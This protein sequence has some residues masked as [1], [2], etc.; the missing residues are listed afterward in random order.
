METFR[1][2]IVQ[3]LPKGVYTTQ[4]GEINFHHTNKFYGTDEPMPPIVE[5]G[6][7][8]PN[9]YGKYLYE[10]D[11]PAY[12]KKKLIPND[13]SSFL[14]ID[15]E[16]LFPDG[17]SFDESFKAADCP[18]TCI[19]IA[20]VYS[21]D[22]HQL[23]LEDFESEDRMIE[24]YCSLVSGSVVIAYNANFDF[25]YIMRRYQVLT[26]IRLNWIDPHLDYISLYK[27]YKKF[28]KPSFKLNDIL[29][30]HLG[31]GKLQYEGSL[32]QLYHTDREK[33]FEYNREDV[34]RL[35]TLERKLKLLDICQHIIKITGCLWQDIIYNSKI[36]DS[37]FY[38]ELSKRGMTFI[39]NYNKHNDDNEEDS[40]EGAVV[41]TP[42]GG[43]YRNSVACYD[44]DSLYPSIILNFNISPETR[45]TISNGSHIRTP[46]NSYYK[47][48]TGLLP[49][50]I[51]YL[52]DARKKAKAEG[53]DEEQ[54]AYKILANSIYGVMGFKKFRLYNEK[55]AEDITL[56]GRF[57][58]MYVAHN[59]D[60]Q[61]SIT[62][63]DE[64]IIWGYAKRREESLATTNILFGHTDSIYVNYPE[65]LA[66]LINDDLLVYFSETY[67]TVPTDYK[68]RVKNE[69]GT[70]KCAIFLNRIKATYFLM[71]QDN[72]F[73]FV[74][75][76]AARS[77][78][79]K[80]AK[81]ILK[82]C[83]EKLMT[84][85]YDLEDIDVRIHDEWMDIDRSNIE[86]WKP[87]KI[88]WSKEYKAIPEC[89]KGLS[90][91]QTIDP[92][93][94]ELEDRGILVHVLG[95]PK[96][97]RAKKPT[98]HV[99]SIP[100]SKISNLDSLLSKLGDYGLKLN[101]NKIYDNLFKPIND[102]VRNLNGNTSDTAMFEGGE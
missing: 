80:F 3:I 89:V 50:L 70:L 34:L 100:E 23:R 56:T 63:I 24:A 35:R 91:F 78:T 37:F 21:E 53:K 59:L 1:N 60:S 7:L 12:R 94:D 84:G 101:E 93:Y 4:I 45:C 102:I 79:T 18:I 82:D 81:Y 16:T 25:D 29:N 38:N 67:N 57:L 27:R 92:G 87:Y 96:S 52:L 86:I 85:Q 26:G 22:S 75:G 71:K 64:D 88:N 55:V 9:Y 11:Y 14:L 32:Y 58:N 31:Y 83:I 33:Y 61:N 41:Y 6:K 69:Y 72:T 62:E 44:F 43:L 68:F 36:L 28:N 90:L 46:T 15:I 30:E 17:R 39:N 73:K 77:N 13:Y 47:S 40:Y 99:L 48:E 10:Q 66:G 20:D 49:S 54:N 5:I 42:A 97:A 98:E 2:N 65:D 8:H 74:G 95:A 76:V 51:V 19:M